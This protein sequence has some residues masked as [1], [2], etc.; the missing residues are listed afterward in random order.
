L[1]PIAFS[2]CNVGTAE[3]DYSNYSFGPQS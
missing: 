3:N 2:A 1:I